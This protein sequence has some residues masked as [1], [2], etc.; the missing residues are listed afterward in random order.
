L[1]AGPGVGG[2]VD[3]ALRVLARRQPA[4]IHELTLGDHD[5]WWWDIDIAAVW[6]ALPELRRLVVCAAGVTL[7]TI[8]HAELAHLKIVTDSLSADSARELAAARCPRLRSLDVWYGEPHNAPDVADLL[9]LLRDVD[10]PALAHLGIRYVL[11]GDAICEHLHR[12]ALAPQ[13]R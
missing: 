5:R 7:G 1:P 13:L 4:A 8:V 2:A 10:L 11:F 3:G 9:P 12:A 6:A